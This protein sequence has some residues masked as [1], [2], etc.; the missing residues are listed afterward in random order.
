M[1]SPPS[2]ADEQPQRRVSFPPDE[3]PIQLRSNTATHTSNPTP[4]TSSPPSTPAALPSNANPAPVSTTINNASNDPIRRRTKNRTVTVDSTSSSSNPPA[5]RR[6]T[7]DSSRRGS[8]YGH[9]PNIGVLR[10]MTTGLFTPEKKIGKA[11]T[12][13]GSAKAAILSTWL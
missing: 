11:P 3:S 2:Y 12:Y 4:Y 13:L 9:D 1:T 6:M 7:S 10:R 5:T 8:T